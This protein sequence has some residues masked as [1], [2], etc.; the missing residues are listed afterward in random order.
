MLGK[1][2]PV[3]TIPPETL[4]QAIGRFRVALDD[5][6]DR[7]SRKLGISAQQ[8]ELLCAAMKPAAVGD[9]AATLRCDRSN[10]SRL[11]DRVAK[12]GLLKRAGDD[13]D[14]RVTLVELT[15]QGEALARR[16][17]ASLESQTFALTERWP[18]QR[19]NL[20]VSII[21]ELSEALE[22]SAK[23]ATKKRRLATQ[24]R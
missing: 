21:G 14:G 1:M 9:L 8:A 17:L 7:A 16:F 6:F 18:A 15:P 19:R 4:P 12:R 23:T 2:C 10:V 3:V 20:A 5:S 13:E 11:I 24:A 22:A